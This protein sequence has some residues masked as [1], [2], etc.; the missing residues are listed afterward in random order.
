[1]SIPFTLSLP[2]ERLSDFHASKTTVIL[3]PLTLLYEESLSIRASRPF[4][5]FKASIPASEE[6]CL[7]RLYPSITMWVAIL[8]FKSRVQRVP[9][10]FAKEV[11]S[12]YCY[13]YS[14]ARVKGQPP[15]NLNIILPSSQY[16]PPTRS[17]RLYPYP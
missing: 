5:I 15:C 14:Q 10:P 8:Y 7:M 3:Y 4:C 16:V 11:V 1:M 13:K 6:D 2:S 9:Y 12:Q 17:R